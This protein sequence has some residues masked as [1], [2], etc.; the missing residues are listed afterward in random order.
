MW[1]SIPPVSVFEENQLLG[2]QQ[3]G[4]KV[5]LGRVCLEA[6][7]PGWIKDW[8]LNNLPTV[9]YRFVMIMLLSLILA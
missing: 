1:E 5:L 6:P 3:I 8:K 7:G 2:C 9:T 4:E